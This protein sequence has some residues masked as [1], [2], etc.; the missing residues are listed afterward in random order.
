MLQKPKKS[1][2]IKKEPIL[3][4]IHNH[5][6]GE[7]TKYRIAKEADTSEPWVLEYTERL[8]QAGLIQGTT[9]LDPRGLYREWLDVRVPPNQLT[10]SLQQPMELLQDTE[11][12][13]ALTTYQAENLIQGYLFPS[14]TDFYIDPKQAD[15]WTQLIEDNGL[16]GGGNTR[17]R[18]SD[19]H[20]FYNT[21]KHGNHVTVSIPQLIVDLM[22]EGGPCEEAA[23]KLIETFHGPVG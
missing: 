19:D 11:H 13:Y 21:R 7:F 2:R 3:R 1:R 9:V 4:L 14:T 20:A 8:E 10:V 23:D 6:H 12:A 22:E 18:V 15:H 17:I 5:P 16:L